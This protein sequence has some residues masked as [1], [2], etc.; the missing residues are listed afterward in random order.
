MTEE[1]TWKTRARRRLSKLAS[2]RATERSRG[3]RSA[4]V[5]RQHDAERPRRRDEDTMPKGREN[6][7]EKGEGGVAKIK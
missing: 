4:I 5:H 6:M 2:T 1:R 7:E 3:S